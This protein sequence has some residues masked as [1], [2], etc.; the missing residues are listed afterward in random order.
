ML[1]CTAFHNGW[2]F[3]NKKC[4]R[5]DYAEKLA[6]LSRFLKKYVPANNKQM[7]ILKLL[8]EYTIN[9]LKIQYICTFFILSVAAMDPCI[10]A[11]RAT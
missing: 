7:Y 11:R 10:A 1:K 5:P 6:F 4:L 3:S 8:I 9:S 2:S